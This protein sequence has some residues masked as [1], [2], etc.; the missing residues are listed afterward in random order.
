MS[1]AGNETK[2]AAGDNG[3]HAVSPG[4][5]VEHFTPS[6]RAARGK[7]ARADVPRSI[8]AA[9]EPSSLRP[10]PVDL[11]EQQGETRVPE[12]VP[13][14]YGRMLVSPFTFYRGAAYIMAADLAG[15]PRTGLHT[16]LC[17]DAHLSNFGGFAAPDRQLVFS[18][19][20]F[21]ETLPGPFEWDV[22]RLVASFA[23]AGRDRGFNEKERMTVNLAVTQA[24]R[25]AIGRF[26]A[27]RN[28][29][30]WYTRINV[31]DLAAR[32][33]QQATSKQLKTFERNLEKTRTKDSIRAFAKLTEIVDGEPHIVG[34]PPL[35]VPIEDV[36]GDQVE[37]LEEALRTI[38]R[39]YRRTLAG[40]RRRLLERFRYAHAA[41]K[42]V[43]VGSVG[44]RAW[45]CLMLGRDGDDPLFLQF[46]EAEASVLEPFLG[47]SEF[48]NHGQRVVEGQ[49][50]TQAAS[51][52]ML[53]WIRTEGIDGLSRD[54]YV[55]QL[56][57]A[58]G[59]AIIEL[60][61]PNAM[62]MYAKACGTELAR[63]HV[64]AGDG[65]AIASYL[66]TSN[67]FDRHLATFAEAY[68]DQNE[69]DYDA[70]KA[71]VESGRVTAVAGM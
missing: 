35:I 19:N 28:L 48:A 71:A 56:W 6:E 60:M 33:R 54:F 62:A 15:V 52:I 46:K 53:G 39:S 3:V 58:K 57:D 25:E 64:R 66:G 37:R 50:L 12:L 41:R 21:D 20:D 23:V 29:D 10:D 51:D 16:Q 47:K 69:R 40:D 34:D 30:L 67:T 13:I 8:H 55:R 18:L 45:I 9:W 26:S 14:R 7:A 31:D 49:R 24:Y 70:L 36:L 68:A 22:K 43:G 1:T 59:S 4:G 61:D 27:M 2:R 32:W 44:T 17:G 5:K 65:I 11:L 38:V 42:V 63:A